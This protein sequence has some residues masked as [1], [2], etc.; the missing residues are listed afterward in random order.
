MNDG[1]DSIYV[2]HLRTEVATIKAEFA[3]RLGYQDS[4]I[5][6][7]RER[8]VK[9]EGRIDGIARDTDVAHDKIRNLREDR[10]G[11][12]ILLWTAVLI[13]VVNLMA[14]IILSLLIYQGSSGHPAM[15]W[16]SGA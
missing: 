9:A 14:V 15:L 6:E 7:L 12:R 10:Q 11:D 4:G 8:M 13:G 1:R 2:D 16:A 3:A 5:I